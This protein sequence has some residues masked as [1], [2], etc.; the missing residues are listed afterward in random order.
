MELTDELKD[1][2]VEIVNSKQMR[3]IG[4]ALQN[5]LENEINSIL[6]NDYEY[7]FNFNMGGGTEHIINYKSQ[8]YYRF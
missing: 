3:S 7:H 6:P 2:I 5:D 4:T 8:S 1:K